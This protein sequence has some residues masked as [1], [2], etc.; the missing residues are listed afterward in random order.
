MDPFNA[1][2]NDWEHVSVHMN[3]GNGQATKFIYHQHGGHYTR[4][5]GKLKKI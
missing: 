2:D 1:H 4:R 3:P 5:C